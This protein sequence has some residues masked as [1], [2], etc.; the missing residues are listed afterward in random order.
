MA[1]YAV[2]VW[3][4]VVLVL[5]MVGAGT[6]GDDW[7]HPPWLWGLLLCLSF[8]AMHTIYW[9]NL[10]MRAPL[11][12]VICLVATVGVRWIVSRTFRARAAGQESSAKIS[13]PSNLDLLPHRQRTVRITVCPAAGRWGRNSQ[14]TEK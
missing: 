10:R 9:S 14:L 5:A 8:T 11:M 12:P 1:R 6:L 7:Y 2:G 4:A 3:Y 13:S